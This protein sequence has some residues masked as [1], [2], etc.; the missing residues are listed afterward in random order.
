MCVL[1]RVE[2]RRL[3]S[4]A[5]DFLYLRQSF[6]GDLALLDPSTQKRL[7]KSGQRHAEV[8]AVGAKQT[9]Y[10]TGRRDGG[11]VRQYDVAADAQRWV[12]M[13]DLNSVVECRTTRHQCG[14]R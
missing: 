4:C 12:G 1:V 2:V 6:A 5:L 9:G 8:V 14:W 7:H 13:G 11:A 3:D 10:R